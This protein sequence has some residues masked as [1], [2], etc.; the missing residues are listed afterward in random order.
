M[1]IFDNIASILR[2]KKPAG[3]DALA[4]LLS[5][6]G[7]DLAAAKQRLSE[8]EA[9]RTDALLGGDAA[10]ARHRADVVSAR[11]D[12]ADLE[13]AV[14]ELQQRLTAAEADAAETRRAAQYKAATEA[15]DRAAAQFARDYPIAMRTLT[16]LLRIVAEADALVDAANEALPSGAEPLAPT[17]ATVRDLPGLSAKVISERSVD[18]WAFPH[19]ERPTSPEQQQRVRPDTDDPSTGT[20]LVRGGVGPEV[21]ERV[22]LRR[23][24]ERRSL[25]AVAGEVGPRLSRM[26][27]PALRAGTP[28]HWVAPTFGL[29]PA[30]ILAR[31]DAA[32]AQ[33]PT[34][35]IDD[36]EPIV[37]LT[38]APEPAMLQAAE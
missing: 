25:P 32:R 4:G 37:T 21:V 15:R 30:S 23:F 11:D 13:I 14:A 18:L 29:S 9:G 10:R 12:V 8:L 27:L 19:A 31:L 36:R 17:E 16:N 20:L 34:A 7:A 26:A 22:V 35:P 38:P 3:A 2:G 5:Q 28:D 6:T 24:I 1:T 33:K